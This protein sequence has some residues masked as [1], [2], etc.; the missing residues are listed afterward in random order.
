MFLLVLVGGSK[1]ASQR[2]HG[3]RIDGQVKLVAQAKGS[4]CSSNP[5]I[6]VRK[7]FLVVQWMSCAIGLYERSVKHGVNVFCLVPFQEFNHFFLDYSGEVVF[8]DFSDEPAENASGI[9]CFAC[10]YETQFSE[11]QVG[12]KQSGH[13]SQA[14]NT[15]HAHGDEGSEKP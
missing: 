12:V 7:A 6:T 14:A 8:S 15:L 3:L 9:G 10:L 2:K 1:S 13:F 11:P 4:A 5:G